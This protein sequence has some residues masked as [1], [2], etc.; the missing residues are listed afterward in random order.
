MPQLRHFLP[1]LRQNN[2]RVDTSLLL[3]PYESRSRLEL[4]YVVPLDRRVSQAHMAL[5]P[6]TATW[7]QQLASC[8]AKWVT[9]DGLVKIDALGS[10]PS[11]LCVGC[12]SAH[13]HRVVGRWAFNSI[14]YCHCAHN[15]GAQQFVSQ[16]ILCNKQSIDCPHRSLPQSCEA[17]ASLSPQ[18]LQVPL[19][20]YMS[21]LVLC[22]CQVIHQ[23][24]AAQVQTSKTGLLA[25]S[26]FL[27]Y[28]MLVA[29]CTSISQAY[30]SLQL[31]ALSIVNHLT[32]TNQD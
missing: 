3:N 30:H 29:Q 26:L 15:V 27:L 16:L 22:I 12:W 18:T 1:Q 5:S 32:K 10:K 28:N 17:P 4:D 19:C 25:T 31:L 8:S 14:F 9:L 13:T 6:G 21:Q 2:G 11:N 20:H 23:P 24:D 7:K